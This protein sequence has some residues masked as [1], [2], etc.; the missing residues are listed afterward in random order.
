MPRSTYFVI[1]AIGLFGILAIQPSTAQESAN[2][3]LSLSVVGVGAADYA[4]SM[5]FYTKIMGF[6][7]A[8]SFSPNGKAHNTYFQV[9]RDTFLE[10]QQ[11]TAN[12]P[13]GLTHIHMH[14]DNVDAVVARLRKTGLAACS[15]SV[16]TSCITDARV[17][18]PTQEKNAVIVDPSG[19]RIEPTESTPGSLTRK[20]MDSWDNKDG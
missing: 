7:P 9:S 16:K 18:A 4:E 3:G 17:A 13:P 19:I 10:L 15:D 1:T 2:L 5:N 12:N 14:T 6:R 20:A 8:F 11:A